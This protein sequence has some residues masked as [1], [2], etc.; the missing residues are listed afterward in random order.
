MNTMLFKSAYDK[1]RL[2][3]EFK[4]AAKQRLMQFGVKP[5]TSSAHTDTGEAKAYTVTAKKNS[6]WK[7]ALGF[8]MLAA[9]V[10]VAVLVGA[11]SGDNAPIDTGSAPLAS[12]SEPS[13][14]VQTEEEELQRLIKNNM[15]MALVELDTLRSGMRY[16]SNVEQIFDITVD[17]G[18][19]SCSAADPDNFSESDSM[20]WGSAGTANAST[21]KEDIKNGESFLCYKLCSSMP[22]LKNA[23]IKITLCGGFCTSVVFTENESSAHNAD[24][25]TELTPLDTVT[26]DGIPIKSTS[27]YSEEQ[28]AE[29]LEAYEALKVFYDKY[30]NVSYPDG[31]KY[32]TSIDDVRYADDLY[33]HY[34]PEIMSFVPEEEI[35]F[36][37]TC[38][39]NEILSSSHKNE[40]CL[41]SKIDGR[42]TTYTEYMSNG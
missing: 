33:S 9:A 24:T 38:A 7:P 20:T 18:T 8:G 35:E 36:W 14:S 13:Q 37:V 5:D 34:D 17:N 39:D 28:K 10:A 4:T 15:T 26:K 29:I 19:W 16:D 21:Q 40:W 6:A 1:V 42:W 25:E 23:S 30:L 22:D 41:V 32:I 11:R 3:E 27:S 12:G 31:S 2:S